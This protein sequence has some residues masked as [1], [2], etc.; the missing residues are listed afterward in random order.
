MTYFI[1]CTYAASMVS[2]VNPIEIGQRVAA[3]E[4]SDDPDFLIGKWSGFATKDSNATR[5]VVPCS[6]KNGTKNRCGC[7]DTVVSKSISN[8]G[9]RFSSSDHRLACC[10]PPIGHK[11]KVI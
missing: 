1:K 11:R 9:D 8:T 6:K 10:T 5:G 7:G 2:H 3:G 4:D